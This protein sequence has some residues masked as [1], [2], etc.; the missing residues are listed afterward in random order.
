MYRVKHVE[1]LRTIQDEYACCGLRNTRDMAWPFPDKTHTAKAC[2]E[3]F[4]RT[5]GCLGSWRGEEQRMAG[6]F[7]G[8][9]GLVAVWQ[10]CSTL[11]FLDSGANIYLKFALIAALTQRQSWLRSIFPGRVSRFI[12]DEENDQTSGQRRAIEHLP[13]FNRY[14]DRIEE[15]TSDGDGG[16]AATRAS[17]DAMQQGRGILTASSNEQEHRA[18]S[19]ENVWFSRSQG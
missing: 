14:S 1:G 5:V 6:I 16:N 10:V 13:D 2:E 11:V 12:R 9:V 3:A 4:G 19:T 7:M 17:E 8:V 18:S 15:E